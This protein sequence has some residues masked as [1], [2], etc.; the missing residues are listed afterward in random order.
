MRSGRGQARQFGA[1]LLRAV[2]G[3]EDAL[4]VGLLAAMVVLAGSQ[5]LLRTLLASGYPWIDPLLRVLVLWLGLLG[6]MAAA[7]LDKHISIDLLE[8]LLPPRGVAALRLITRLF[9]AAVAGTVAYHSARFV[10]AERE[11][12][13]LLFAAVPVWLCELIIPLAFALIALR[14]LLRAAGVGRERPR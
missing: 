12:G 9:T 2:D 4:L 5:I 11:A 1:G 13:T 3:L 6:A 7:R 14:Y 8:R 10:A